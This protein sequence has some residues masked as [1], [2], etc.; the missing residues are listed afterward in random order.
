[1]AAYWLMSARFRRSDLAFSNGRH[2]EG[3]WK[4]IHITIAPFSCKQDQKTEES[5]TMVTVVIETKHAMHLQTFIASCYVEAPLTCRQ[6]ISSRI[7]MLFQKVA[8]HFH[9]K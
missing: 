8:R 7:L 1:M 4:G 9:L 5:S 2:A 6:A 3:F